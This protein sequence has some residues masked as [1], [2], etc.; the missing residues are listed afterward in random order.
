MTEHTIKLDGAQTEIVLA[1]LYVLADL[2]GAEVGSDI[3]VEMVETAEAIEAQLVGYGA[4]L[5]PVP[6]LREMAVDEVLTA[7]YANF[8]RTKEGFTQR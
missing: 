3:E 4:H 1:A 6:A 8:K 2:A 5:R 7:V